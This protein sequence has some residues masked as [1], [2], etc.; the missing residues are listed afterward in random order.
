[1]KQKEQKEYKDGYGVYY[2]VAWD[3]RVNTYEFTELADDDDLER[4]KDDEES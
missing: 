2:Y 1:M 3:E 4:E